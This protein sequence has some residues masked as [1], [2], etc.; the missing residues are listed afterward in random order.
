MRFVIIITLCPRERRQPEAP[1]D[2]FCFTR[3]Q[4]RHI[5]NAVINDYSLDIDE[6]VIYDADF[7]CSGNELDPA[8]AMPDL[9]DY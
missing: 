2:T 7:A 1:V 6:V 8:I 5:V 4:S 3:C 9:Q